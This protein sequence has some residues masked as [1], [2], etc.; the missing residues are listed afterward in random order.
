MGQTL[1]VVAKNETKKPAC[2]SRE[3]A[4]AE[5]RQAEYLLSGEDERGRRVWFYRVQVTGLHTR[6]FGPFAQKADAIAAFD[7]FLSGVLEALCECLNSINGRQ[8]RGMEF[9]QLPAYLNGKGR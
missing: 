3:S 2:A 9:I 5:D 1:R 8:N 4:L 6:V 7:T